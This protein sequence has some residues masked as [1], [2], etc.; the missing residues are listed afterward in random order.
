MSAE[1]R[2][3]MALKMWY[4][5]TQFRGVTIGLET[6]WAGTIKKVNKAHDK[7]KEGKMTEQDLKKWKKF[8]L[9]KVYPNTEKSKPFRLMIEGLGLEYNPNVED[10]FN[11]LIKDIQDSKLKAFEEHMKHWT[12][13]QV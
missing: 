2:E 11:I 10:V 4:G 12:G 5:A 8:M 6:A 1:Q 13:K 7:I 3:E 9:K